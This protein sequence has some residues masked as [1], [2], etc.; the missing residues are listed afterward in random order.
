M[1]GGVVFGAAFGVEGV[2][3][4]VGLGARPDRTTRAGPSVVIMQP[5][6]PR[7]L[8]PPNGISGSVPL[9]IFVDLVNEVLLQIVG[10]RLLRSPILHGTCDCP[11]F[12]CSPITSI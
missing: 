9:T 12:A 3:G 1:L 4:D 11:P 5:E 6:R 7:S 2:E 10:T 8:G